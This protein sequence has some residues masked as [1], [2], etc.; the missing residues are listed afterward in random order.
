MSWFY[1]LAFAAAGWALARALRGGDEV[2]KGGPAEPA[3]PVCYKH[4]V[5]DHPDIVEAFEA[6]HG[7]KP[8]TIPAKFCPGFRM[9]GSFFLYL[10]GHPG[11]AYGDV[12]VVS[13]AGERVSGRN[14]P[15]YPYLHLSLYPDQDD[16]LS[17]VTWERIESSLPALVLESV[18][19]GLSIYGMGSKE[20]GWVADLAREI[21]ATNQDSAA[22][23]EL[24][25]EHGL[26]FSQNIQAAKPDPEEI[27]MSRAVE[28]NFSSARW[29]GDQ[30]IISNYD[31]EHLIVDRKERTLEVPAQGEI[32]VF[33]LD[34]LK[35]TRKDRE[36]DS[37]TK[38][39]QYCYIFFEQGKKCASVYQRFKDYYEGGWVQAELDKSQSSAKAKLA[40]LAKAL[41]SGD[42]SKLPRH[43]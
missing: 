43:R 2:S 15:Q 1:K 26:I 6:E 33:S 38:T 28:L 32:V 10:G 35:V 11:S 39:H 8:P 22:L 36:V 37:D 23:R 4:F 34:D 7:R 12:T 18:R 25:L 3:Y 13:R 5:S 30:Y 17:S 41:Q 21:L 40:R 27:L 16:G 24:C 29:D 31:G 20:H 9:A 14:Y 42:P 19:V